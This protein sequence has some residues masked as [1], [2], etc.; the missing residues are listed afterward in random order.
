MYNEY[1]CYVQYYSCEKKKLNLFVKK[2][3]SE[4]YV[5]GCLIESHIREIERERT[6]VCL[7]LEPN[8]LCVCMLCIQC[9]YIFC[10][11]RER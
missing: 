1:A 9:I 3:R 2:N 8:L 6:C 4:F 10:T 11:E 7:C 5:R